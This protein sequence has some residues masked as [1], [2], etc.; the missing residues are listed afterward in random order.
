MRRICL[1]PTGSGLK[2]IPA[3]EIR[4]DFEFIL[5]NSHYPCPYYIADFLS[6]LI[7]RL[8][9]ADPTLSEFFIETADLNG[10]FKDIIAIGYGETI[11]FPEAERDF[12]ISIFHEFDNLEF[13]HSI[14]GNPEAALSIS[15]AMERLRFHHK[16]GLFCDD[17]I[18]FI[19]AHFS[20]LPISAFDNLSDDI[21]ALI[22]SNREL[23][24]ASEDGLY[25][26]I[27][28]RIGRDLSSVPLLE[29]VQFE[30]LLPNTV[31]RFCDSSHKFCDHI[32]VA[33]WERICRRL[34]HAIV[35]TS[36]NSRLLHPPGILLQPNSNSVLEG[37]VISYLSG[38]YG[39]DFASHSV[40]EVTGSSTESDFPGCS[41]I[42]VTALKADSCYMS[43]NAPNQW[44]CYHFCKSRIWPTHYTIR[45][46]H[47]G[48]PNCAHPRSWVIQGSFD[49]DTLIEID[50][51]DNCSELNG[52]NI[53][54]CYEISRP[55]EYAFIRLEQTA[56][57][58][59]NTHRLILSGFEVFGT[60]FEFSK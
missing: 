14:I 35:P 54:R 32:T 8:H 5:G 24:I 17:I 41:P 46:W 27:S 45:S 29:Y 21:I 9:G 7:G 20:E 52:R 34:V 30:F 51:R 31:S 48:G 53:A 25:D 4:N 49:G 44:I 22:L 12:F 50:R 57:C 42:S 39:S 19:A 15:N 36:A 58:W 38:K 40:L 37:G 26:L 1:R 18:P 2:N 56:L 33:L 11:A 23:K 6:P 10:R 55:G 16:F 13:L 60:L 43:K 28:S 47:T 3:L 59:N